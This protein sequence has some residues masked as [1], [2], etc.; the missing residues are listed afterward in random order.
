MRL[1]SPSANGSFVREASM[2]H[3]APWPWRRA[4][5][6]NRLEMAPEG[7]KFESPYLEYS[8]VLRSCQ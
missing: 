5:R 6:L 2:A 4:D 1:A 7:F 3:G 8:N